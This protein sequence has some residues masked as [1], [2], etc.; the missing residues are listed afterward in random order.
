MN[1]TIS[2]IIPNQYINTLKAEINNF[3][4]KEL[5]IDPYILD[6][7]FDSSFPKILKIIINVRYNR[8]LYTNIQYEIDLNDSENIEWIHMLGKSGN[9][10]EILIMEESSELH[11]SD[12]TLDSYDEDNEFD[13][14]LENN[15]SHTII[16]D[17]EKLPSIHETLQ[18]ANLE[19]VRDL[20]FY[21]IRKHLLLRNGVMVKTCFYS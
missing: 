5:E 11:N 7:K 20:N 19:I 3:F 13:Y 1:T 16:Y 15:S 17:E 10:A 14:E 9:K 8:I 18:E 4:Y 2:N 12:E 21:L 6:I